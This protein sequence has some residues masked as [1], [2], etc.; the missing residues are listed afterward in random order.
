VLANFRPGLAERYELDYPSIVRTN[1]RVIYAE[2][3]AFG[4]AGPLADAPGMDVVLQGVTG[5]A[6]FS[7]RG[8]EQNDGPMIDQTAAILMAWG[9]STALYH[10]ERA[11]VGQRLDV[12]LMH[13]AML[14]ENN[15][16]T[17]VDL[18]DGWRHEF[19]EYLKTAFSEGETWADILRRRQEMQ[20]HRVM[21]AYYGFFE[22]ADGSVAVACNARNLRRRMA[23]LL[24]ISDRWT[25]EQDW[26]PEDVESHEAFVRE[27]VV[28]ALKAKTSAECI[29]EFSAAGLPIGPL[30]HPDELF[31]DPQAWA[32]GF[33][34]RIEHEVVGG[35]TIVAPPVKFSETPLSAQ[36]TVPLGKH[37]REILAEAG[38][39]PAAIDLLF[40]R[41]LVKQVYETLD[42][43][44]A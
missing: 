32:N 39:E 37:S 25:T 13:A 19:V 40:E 7:E 44:L 1:P 18:T 24:G 36:P 34:A 9:V 12:A 35:M 27:Q 42:D 22:T 11:G 5:F 31:D 23:A 29:A 3:T 43:F 21:R 38:L 20:P 4:R 15:A 10:R 26:Y 8:P 33:F 16:L 2:N 30:R 41:G 14:M 17:H 28:R 6:H